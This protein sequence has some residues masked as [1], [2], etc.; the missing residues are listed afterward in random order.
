[1]AVC[2][3]CEKDFERG[4]TYM[5]RRYRQDKQFRAKKIAQAMAWQRDT[6]RKAVLG[7]G[8]ACKFCGRTDVE[9]L[10]IKSPE[11]RLFPQFSMITDL[12][13]EGFPV[14]GAVVTCKQ[15]NHLS[16]GDYNTPT[17]HD[18]PV[19]DVAESE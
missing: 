16:P 14:G 15:R 1:M 12:I 11:H 18:A 8:G 17:K 4:E 9:K 19:A 7:Y 13:R 3:I 5:Q 6:I 2:E 10:T